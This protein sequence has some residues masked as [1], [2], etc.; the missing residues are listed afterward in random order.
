MGSYC[1]ACE[2]IRG[3]EKARKALATPEGREKHRL[4]SLKHSRKLVT[5]SVTNALLPNSTIQQRK[6]VTDPLTG[7]LI[8]RG[9]LAARKRIRNGKR[10]EYYKGYM[11]KRLATDLIFKL[12]QQLGT[13]IRSHLRRRGV[14]KTSKT[15]K[16]VGLNGQEL[17]AYFDTKYPNWQQ[18]ENLTID[19][20]LPVSCASNEEE[21]LALQ[22]Y[23]N[24]RP[25]SQVENLSKSDTLPDNWREELARLKSIPR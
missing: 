23:S 11:R 15:A 21:L 10:A 17:C 16:L 22:H 8:T 24:L 19:H 12:S 1:K 5:D 7:E 6:L 25:L 9:A 20:I 13:L 14:H 4:A 2:K 18:I 3:R